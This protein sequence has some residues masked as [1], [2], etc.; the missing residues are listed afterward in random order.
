MKKYK[1]KNALG[2][3]L[4]LLGGGS[5][6][7]GVSALGEIHKEVGEREQVSDVNPDSHLSSRSADAAGNKEVRD[8]DAHSDKELSDLHRSQVLLARGVESDRGGGVVG[9]HDGVDERVEDDKDPDGG[10]LVVDA[11]P[12]GDHGAGVVIGLEKGRA[13]AFEDDDDGVDDFVE[14]G[15]VED[16]TPVTER[17]VPEG[18]VS[19]TVLF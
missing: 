13:A 12:H 1:A 6:A 16:V 18:L 4:G 17:A 8:S 10:G 15:E 11:G 9:V 5:R 7:L 3:L 19:I 14:L 2:F